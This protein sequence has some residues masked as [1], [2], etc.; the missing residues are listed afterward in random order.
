M[1]QLV[2]LEGKHTTQN[3][4]CAMGKW[5]LAVQDSWGQ[6]PV[7]LLGNLDKIAFLTLENCTIRDKFTYLKEGRL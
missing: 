3:A 7:E 2:R 1:S 6:T 4:H 5:F